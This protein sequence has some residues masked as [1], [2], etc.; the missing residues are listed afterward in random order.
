MLVMAAVAAPFVVSVVLPPNLF[1]S[2]PS[3]RQWHADGASVR[4]V[5]GETIGL[6]DRIVRLAGLAAPAR[7][8]ACRGGAGQ[9][10]DCGAAAAAALTRLVAGRDV[11]CRIVGQDGFGR[12]LGECETVAGPINRTLVADGF[13]V[14]TDAALRGQEAAARQ[15]SRGLWAHGA[16]APPGW[17]AR[18]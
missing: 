14:A 12:G 8:D 15:Q 13:A 4:I 7:G 11:G 17:P 2:A 3:D 10:F 16:G 9:G 1:G 6:G 18:D 5:D